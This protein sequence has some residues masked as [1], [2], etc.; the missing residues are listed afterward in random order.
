M[1]YRARKLVIRRTEILELIRLAVFVVT[2]IAAVYLIDLMAVTGLYDLFSLTRIGR[3]G[4]R[5]RHRHDLGIPVPPGLQDPLPVRGPL[6]PACRIQPGSGCTARKPA[7]GAGNARRSVRRAQRE[8]TI[9]S[10]NATSAAGVPMPARSILRSC[11]ATKNPAK[12]FSFHSP[13]NRY[14]T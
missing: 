4:S 13:M 11:T 12:I 8:N 2:V 6:L 7:S 10:G 14:G 9:Q 5:S 1:P 3:A